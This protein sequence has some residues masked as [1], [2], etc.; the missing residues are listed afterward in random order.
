M[1]KSRELLAILLLA[2]ATLACVAAC[3]PSPTDS[4]SNSTNSNSTTA[5]PNADSSSNST[6]GDSTLTP[7]SG[8]HVH[9]YTETVTAPTCTEGGFTTYTCECGDNYT[10]TPVQK[11]GHTESDWIVD[12]EATYENAGSK[13]KECTVCHEVLQTEEIPVLE[14]TA[15]E[16]LEYTLS[17]DGIYYI[18]S[19]I[20]TCTDTALVIP[21][22][23]EGKPITSIG[24]DAFDACERLTSVVIPDSVTSIGCNAFEDCANLTS[25]MIGDGVTSI[26]N[27]AFRDCGNLT[28][29]TVHE[30]NANYQ[31]IDG[32]LY[33]KNGKIFIQYAIGK[34]A[35]EFTIPD[36]VTTI[37]EYAFRSCDS[38]TSITVHEGNANYQSIDGNLYTKDGET[39]IQYA[40]GKIATKF[41]IPDGVTSIGRGAFENCDN[42]TSIV[43]GNSV[44]SIGLSAF[45]N[46]A[47]LTSVVIGDSVTSIDDLAFDYCKS[48]T[49]VYYK[50]LEKDW[51]KISIGYFYNDNLIN[52]TRYY[53]S[54]NQPTEEG[55]YWHYVN[56]RIAIWGDVL[57]ASE[58]LKY[59]LSYDGTYYIVSGIGTCE[60]TDIVIA[61]TYKGLPVKTIGEDAFSNCT[62]LTSVVIGDSVTLIDDS[63]FRNCDSLTSVMIGDSVT[64][65]GSWAFAYCD[66]LTSMVIPDSVTS[67]DDSAFRFC[68]SLTSMVIPD[69]VTSID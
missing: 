18:V 68:N 25:V 49:S 29:I 56:G 53:Y 42:L 8:E 65:I 5:P 55:N 3:G 41:T 33:T 44:T 30:G 46:C 43:I 7:P 2:S 36:S 16:G 22:T 45:E 6:D 24:D 1:K 13:Y 14:K 37:D 61:N 26:G 39:L 20:G 62:S 40:I 38:L 32:N 69:S 31:S 63:A 35:T 27:Q 48:L 34:T 4:S 64:S 59:T 28:S 51:K 54:E 21:S 58:G 47:N 66:S 11:L 19:G 57:K 23:Y 12:K 52:A 10:D 67:I 15:S 17:D 60:D 9:S 50:G